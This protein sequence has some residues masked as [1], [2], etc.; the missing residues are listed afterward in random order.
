M[1]R[2]L[3]W[4][5]AVWSARQGDMEPDLP[6]QAVSCDP[7]HTRSPCLTP[8]RQ[9]G[10]SSQLGRRALTCNPLWSG[11][12]FRIIGREKFRLGW[13]SEAMQVS[14][15]PQRRRPRAESLIHSHCLPTPSQT[16]HHAKP[17]L[18]LST[19]WPQNTTRELNVFTWKRRGKGSRNAWLD[20]SD[21]DRKMWFKMWFLSDCKTAMNISCATL[22][23]NGFHCF[24]PF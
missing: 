7:E 15:F 16:I 4:I 13:S 17:S 22:L 12:G 3:W 23:I 20:A 9:H 1:T 19:W 10:W 18:L 14:S 6:W 11:E 21:S 5:M 2:E 8:W 24:S